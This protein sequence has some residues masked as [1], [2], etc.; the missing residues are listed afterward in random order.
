MIVP[1]YQPVPEPTRLPAP[2]RD[3][4]QGRRRIHYLPNPPPQA[5]QGKGGGSANAI[6]YERDRLDVG[7]AIGGPAIIE[8]FDATTVIPP[9]WSGTVDGYR[10]LVLRRE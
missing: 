10:N 9:G 1:K 4:H 6:L 2:H 3:R 5:G 8:Q 7:A